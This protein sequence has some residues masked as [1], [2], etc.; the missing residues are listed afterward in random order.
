M[1]KLVFFLLF[2]FGLIDLMGQTSNPKLKIAHLTNNFYIY[3]TYSTYNDVATP[4]HG[5]YLVGDSGV[6]LFDTPW[7]STQFQALLDSIEARHHKSVTLCIAA[8]WHSDRTAGLEYYKQKGIKTYTTQFTD[9]L[10]KINNH[11]RAEFLMQNDTTFHFDRYT[12]ETYYPGQGH[13]LDNIIV[14][15]PKERILYG[16]CLIKGGTAVNLG[17]LGD[18]N[19][20]EYYNT[21]KRVEKKCPDPNYI[22]ISHSDWNDPNSLRRSIKLAK[23]LRKAK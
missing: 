15:F 20:K 22:V 21:L 13:T 23:K 19:K 16:G 12:F 1:Q 18:A 7:D 9:E 3:T 14:W 8:H 4:A 11:K 2:I 17:F 10:A 6:A 5:M